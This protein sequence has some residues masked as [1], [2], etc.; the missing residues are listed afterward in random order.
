MRHGTA[1]VW[2]RLDLRIADN[3]ALRAATSAGEV[4]PVFIHAPHEEAP[5]EPGAASRWWLHQSLAAL[6][7]A[8]KTAGSRLVVRRG[9]TLQALQQL[10]EQT[11]AQAVFWNRR[12]EPAVIA[13]DEEV[14]ETLSARGLV[15][16]SFNGALLNE[17]STVRN[18]NGKPFQVFTPFWRN[19][20]AR[21]VPA[22]PLA[23]PRRIPAPRHWPASVLLQKLELEPKLD[24][25]EGIRAAWTPGEAGARAQ[26]KLFLA[27]G[28][29]DYT[30]ERNRPGCPGTSRLSPHLHFGEITPRQIWQAVQKHSEANGIT[31]QTWRSSQFLAEVGWREFAHHFLYHF[32]T[33]PAEPLRKDF[34]NFRWHTNPE[35]LRVWQHGL[36]GYPIVDAGMRE[37]WV[38]GWMHNRVRMIVASFLVKDLLI[39]WQ[40]GAR[41]FWD[42]LV[43]ADLAQNTLGWQWTTGCGAD[44]APWF[45]VFNPVGQGEKFDPTGE[46]VRKWCPEL[47]RLPDRW[48][49][50]PWQAP[51]AVVANAGVRIGRNYPAPIVSHA[52]AREAALEAFARIKND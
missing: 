9:P 12:Y 31:G 14:K 49:H 52:I 21:R 29:K 20:L 27:N 36:T 24:W 18:Q 35:F 6:A 17:P 50:K 43:D 23:A 48:L 1:I 15:V 32:P 4:V 25:A 19:C 30:E 3:P 45:R 46:Y 47:A 28:I 11:G 5:W 10:V 34:L 8:L 2:F 40:E 7:N 37:L 42:T 38:T 39:S 44:A 13:R 33:T 51:Q 16:E 22:E 26:L 41:W